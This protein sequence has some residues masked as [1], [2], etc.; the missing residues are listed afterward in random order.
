MPI[1]PQ[2]HVVSYKLFGFVK[3]CIIRV[4]GDLSSKE[5][6]VSKAWFCIARYWNIFTSDF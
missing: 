4:R 1:I 5:R 6:K 3:C 2:Y